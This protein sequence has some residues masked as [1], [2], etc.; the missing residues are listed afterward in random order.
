[1]TDQLLLL[2]KEPPLAWIIFNR[3]QKLNA[4][5]FETWQTLPKVVEEVGNDSDLRVLLIRGAGEN[6]FTAGADIPQFGREIAE[7]V[8]P[9]DY[10]K[11]VVRAGIALSQL[12]KPVIAMIHGVCMGGGFFLAIRC[13]LRLAADDA[14]FSI[15]AVRLG[16][17]YSSFEHV[18]RLVQVL[19]PA[20][21]AEIA[22][23]GRIFNAEEA[24]HMGLVHRVLPKAE[25]ESYTR[26]YA[27]K[28]AN[29]APLSLAGTK[30]AIRESLKV[31]SQRDLE[32]FQTLLAQCYASEDY[33]EGIAAFLEKRKPRFRGK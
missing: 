13:D 23:T 19:G 8:S 24:Y 21:A 14:K 1:M 22:L 29:N 2:R 9:T 27:L 33:K 5:T 12:E 31:S 3:P 18:G 17:A 25:L 26:D 7:E 15:T 28:I 32:R 20:N 10:E 11:V 16:A 30:V 4:V 6:A